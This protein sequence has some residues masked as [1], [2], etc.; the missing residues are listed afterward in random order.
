VQNDEYDHDNNQNVNPIAG[1]RESW[2]YVPTQEA[3]QPQ[4]EQ[5]HY[6]SPQH[7]IS[8]FE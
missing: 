7:E 6:D 5:N 4:D 3:E 2:A 1:A 8:P